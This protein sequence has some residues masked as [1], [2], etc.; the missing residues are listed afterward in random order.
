MCVYVCV[1]VYVCV[2]VCVC[3][4]WRHG[5]AQVSGVILYLTRGHVRLKEIV[6]KDKLQ[7]VG[8]YE[9]RVKSIL[10]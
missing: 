6:S 3:V 8:Q 9:E 2:C 4:Y 7:F 5:M 1:Y 10:K